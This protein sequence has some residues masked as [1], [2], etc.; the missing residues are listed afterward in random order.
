MNSLGPI[1][2]IIAACVCIAFYGVTILIEKDKDK[3]IQEWLARCHFGLNSDKY[4]TAEFE[5]KQ[6]DRAFQ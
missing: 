6:L 4:A 1:G 5:Q 2:W 3:K